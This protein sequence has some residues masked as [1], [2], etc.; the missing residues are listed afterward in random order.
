VSL[1]DANSIGQW[2]RQVDKLEKKR[3]R[4]N[5]GQQTRPDARDAGNEIAIEEARKRASWYP[6]PDDP[7]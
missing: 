5:E 7:T 6:H 2:I 3:E 4:T 1:H